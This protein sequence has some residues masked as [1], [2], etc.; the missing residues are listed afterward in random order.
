MVPQDVRNLD[1][2]GQINN[3]MYS[4]IEGEVIQVSKY[5]QR[6]NNILLQFSPIATPLATTLCELRLTVVLQA[7]AP[8]T[9]AEGRPACVGGAQASQG[10]PRAALEALEGCEHRRGRACLE[11]SPAH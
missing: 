5:R 2:I 7:W 8:P 4:K 9:Q 1:K 3:Y 11:G 10:T 6:L